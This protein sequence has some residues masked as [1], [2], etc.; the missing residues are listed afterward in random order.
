MNFKDD[1][2]NEKSLNSY[3]ECLKGGIEKQEK[4][5]KKVYGDK[6]FKVDLDTL[7]Y[8][9]LVYQIDTLKIVL[10]DLEEIDFHQK[11][12]ER[13]KDN[14]ILSFWKDLY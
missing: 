1:G 14:R 6:K 3:I 12:Q 8:M 4:F 10:T 9:N 11:E 2:D 7:G 5:A 13:E